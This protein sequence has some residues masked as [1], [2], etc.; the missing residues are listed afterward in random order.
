LIEEEFSKCP[1]CNS[2]DGYE[3]SG[4]IGKYAQCLKCMTKWQ[5]F[6]K[7]NR[8][9]ELKLHELPKNGRAVHTITTTKAPLFTII[10]KRLPTG[11]WKDLELDK[12]INW[13]FLSKSIGSDVSKAVFAEKGEKLLYQW[14][15]T[16]EVHEETI[17]SGKPYK[18]V[19]PEQGILLLSNRKLRWLR[20]REHGVW[21]KATSFLVVYEIPLQEVKGV[22]GETGDSSEYITRVAKTVK[23]VRALLEAGFEYVIEMDGLK[24]FRKRK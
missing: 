21:K 2:T 1:I 13:E 20:R 9:L 8:L 5:L 11:F 16:R 12:E 19:K 18:F 7:D 17:I 6:M 22:S 10:G 14:E 4:I 15:G 23:G 3:F 24:L